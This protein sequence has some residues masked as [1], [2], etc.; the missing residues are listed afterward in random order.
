MLCV[1]VE[2][3]L[4]VRLAPPFV[5]VPVPIVVVPSLNVTVP[6][7]DGVPPVGRIVAVSVTDAPNVVVAGFAATLVVVPSV[8]TVT[9]VTALVEVA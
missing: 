3:V 7:A 8:F 5:T 4:N 9:T 2:S 1:P 6:V